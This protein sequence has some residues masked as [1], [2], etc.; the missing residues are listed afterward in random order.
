MTRGLAIAGVPLIVAV[1]AWPLLAQ[2]SQPPKQPPKQPAKT[3]PKTPAK[4]AKKD[5]PAKPAPPPPDVSV[6]AD[7]V[8]GD[9]TTTGTVLMHGSRQ[10]V[11][12]EAT[13]AS[14]QMCDLHQSVQLN[15]QTKVYLQMA[16]PVP[17]S[18][19]ATPAGA[20]KK[21]GTITYTTAVVD[22]GETKDA[23]GFTAH[24][25]KTTITKESSPDALDKRPEKVEIDGWYVGMPDSVSC[26]GAAPPEREI[27]VDAKDAA[28]SDVVTYVR[29]APTKAYPVSYTMTTT[30]GTDAPVTTKMDA[31]EVKRTTLD[32]HQFDIP[33]DYIAVKLPVE[34]TLDHRPGEVG[35]K[36]PGNIRVG[37]APFANTS[38]QPVA[39][40]DLSRALFDSLEESATDVVLLKGETPAEQADEAKKLEC[41]YVLTNTVSEMKRPGRGMLG[42]IGGSN[43]DA[44]SAKL[45]Y[46]LAAPGAAKPAV[47]GSEHSGT[48][49]LQ[50]AIAAGKR[51]SMFITPMMMARYGYM[52]AFSA[53]RGNA[54]AGMMQSTQDPVLSAVFSF[55]DR[56]TGT[57]PQPVLTNEDGAAAAALQ[58]EIDDVVANLKKIKS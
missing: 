54:T 17:A 14:L 15:N 58:K 9:K 29:P 47:A 44:L 23:F 7:Y 22:T 21:G 45:D 18:I 1:T 52:S 2:S 30:A 6:T 51:V 3:A 38:G 19:P 25:L 40:A 33:D 39:T 46:T 26:M 56:A 37:I 12:Y 50:T 31:T 42:K 10:R 13:F 57:K 55:V 8:A 48:S 49:T 35:A 36:K 16:D 32:P 24:H 41:D 34:L 20:K 4:G 11:S 53:M 43:A 27:R 5:E 28:A